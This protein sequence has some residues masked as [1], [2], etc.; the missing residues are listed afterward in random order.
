MVKSTDWWTIKWNLS[1]IIIILLS[2]F[3]LPYFYYNNFTFLIISLSNFPVSFQV[4]LSLVLDLWWLFRT[5]FVF[6]WG[7]DYYC[8]I[9]DKIIY[10]MPNNSTFVNFIPI[11]RS[12]YLSPPIRDTGLLLLN[13]FLQF[14]INLYQTIFLIFQ[15]Y[16]FFQASC[17][18]GYCV[19]LVSF[20]YN[21]SLSKISQEGWNI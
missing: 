6:P 5:L 12:T 14:A 10:I 8:P 21:L 18:I 4:L 16:V 15:T 1:D 3:L 2:L 7:R 17:I 11:E 19:F 9:N 20:C 13:C